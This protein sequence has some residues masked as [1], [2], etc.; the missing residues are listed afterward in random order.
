MYL[1]GKSG[2]MPKPLLSKI[3]SDLREALNC[4]DLIVHYSF[5]DTPG[6]LVQT[7]RYITRA[8]FRDS[9]WD[10]YMARELFNFRNIRW[11]GD[12]Q[13]EAVWQLSQAEAE[14]ED[15]AGLEAV[16]KL[17]SGICP[18]CGQPLRVLH[19][20]F[21]TGEPVRWSQ[22]IDSTYLAIWSAVEI[23]GTGYYR[24][25]WQSRSGTVLSP[26]EILRLQALAAR[27]RQKPSVNPS[28]VAMRQPLDKL[29][30]DFHQQRLSRKQQ[31][32]RDNAAWA[33]IELCELLWRA[34]GDGLSIRPKDEAIK[35]L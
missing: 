10:G 1:R 24:I 20:K 19:H 26:G 32:A 30:S 12:W 18:D 2:Y 7:V 9:T 13:G 14:G 31:L 6:Q 11:W 27:A 23:A 5:K 16:S 21:G 15:I 33:Y 3:Q 8:T 22:P 29:R 25:P 35:L 34:N 4:A 28:A 17:Q